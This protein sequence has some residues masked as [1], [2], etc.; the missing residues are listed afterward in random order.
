M[1]NIFVN[2]AARLQ[3]S[4]PTAFANATN[5]IQQFRGKVSSSLLATMGAAQMAQKA[6][7]YLTQTFAQV[8]AEAKKFEKQGARLGL[9]PSEME[10]FSKLAE[11]SGVSEKAIVKGLNKIKAAA[12]EALRDPA[13]KSAEA[14][15]ALGVSTEQLEQGLLEPVKLF[16]ITSDR[17]NEI[18][19]EGQKQEALGAIFGANGTMLAGVIE[20]GSEGQKKLMEGNS[21]M[22]DL[23]IGQNAAM[24][25]SWEKFWD[26]IKVGVASLA[27]ILNPLVQILRMIL[28]VLSM[29]VK[30]V[31]FLFPLLQAAFGVMAKIGQGIFWVWEKVLGIAGKLMRVIGFLP[32]AM[33]AAAKKAADFLDA[34]GGAAAEAKGMAGAA[35][36][37]LFE[38]AGDNALGIVNSIKED[39]RDIIDS[40]KAIVA[41]YG[42]KKKSKSPVDREFKPMSEEEKKKRETMGAKNKALKEEIEQAEKMAAIEDEQKK[43]MAQRV[44]YGIEETKLRKAMDAISDKSSSAYLE[45]EHELLELIKKRNEFERKWAEDLKKQ[46]IKDAEELAKKE[47]ELMKERY[48]T[49]N[50]L[51]DVA[52]KMQER[53]MKAEGKTDVEIKAARFAKEMETLDK[54]RAEYAAYQKSVGGKDTV[55]GQ[56]MLQEML[57]KGN[58]LD[59]LSYEINSANLKGA[60]FADDMRKKGM[61]GQA[62]AG[63]VTSIEIAKK[64]EGHLAALRKMAAEQLAKGASGSAFSVIQQSGKASASGLASDNSPK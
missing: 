54:M 57:N 42:D 19:E 63:A 9:K 26:A 43:N 49:Q 37:G 7:G 55:Q 18:N 2:I 44:L 16:G 61:G 50:V 12:G 5:Y 51:M 46:K 4:F 53:A 45:A 21:T 39:G 52:T 10:Q 27:V 58:E 11:E 25:D 24:K 22:G 31:G 60:G 13:S 62:V 40:G 41:G 29:V 15:R 59:A 23:L 38:A 56:K 6:I 33:G 35:A 64:S 47:E 48:T 8:T 14:F 36:D 30:M 32:G 20:E 34:M 1:A 28:N 3:A 17:I